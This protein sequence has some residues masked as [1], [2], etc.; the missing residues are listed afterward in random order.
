MI[1]Q[2]VAQLL[3]SKDTCFLWFT[4]PCFLPIFPFN[5]TDFGIEVTTFLC[6][7]RARFK[8]RSDG[9]QNKTRKRK[10]QVLL[11]LTSLQLSKVLAWKSSAKFLWTSRFLD[12]SLRKLTSRVATQ[13]NT[14]FR[15]RSLKYLKE[16]ILGTYSAFSGEVLVFNTLLKNL[17]KL[18][19]HGL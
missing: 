14:T 16:F 9:D 5:G 13:V 4:A 3:Q 15:P 10:D 11:G 17:Y 7:T 6:F 12:H 18:L 2:V 8:V 1:V 19:G